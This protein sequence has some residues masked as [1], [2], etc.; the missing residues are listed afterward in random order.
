MRST[1]TPSSGAPEVDKFEEPAYKV[2]RAKQFPF[3]PMSVEEAILQMNLIGHSFF[4]FR[5]EERDGVFSVV[6]R[7]NDGDYGILI[8]TE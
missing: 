2:V 3:R 1:P 8:D 5:N 7:R 4:A 6:Y